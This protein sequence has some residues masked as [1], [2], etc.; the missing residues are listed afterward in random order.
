MSTT[1]SNYLHNQQ[2]NEA[3]QCNLD[4]LATETRTQV[5]Q[6]PTATTGPELDPMFSLLQQL[7]RQEDQARHAEDI[8]Q[9]RA[10]MAALLEVK[11]IPTIVT[12]PPPAS[13]LAPA[14]CWTY[15][16]AEIKRFEQQ[17]AAFAVPRDRWAA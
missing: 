3:L 14:L 15:A 7:Q 2:S 9:H 10:D 17:M 4:T 16:E 11:S 12:T 5:F 1:E 8:R 6:P 13:K